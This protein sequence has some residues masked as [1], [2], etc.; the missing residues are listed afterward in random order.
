MMYERYG[1]Y[2]ADRCG[3]GRYGSTEGISLIDMYN[4]CHGM[5]RMG[6]S[7]TDITQ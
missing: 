4:V 3:N 5:A 2:K 6:W 1:V 7:L